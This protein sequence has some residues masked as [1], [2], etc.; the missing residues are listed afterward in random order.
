MAATDTIMYSI[1]PATGE[2]IGRYDAHTGAILQDILSQATSA[3]KVWSQKSFENRSRVF[4]RLAAVLRQQ[5]G[6]LA[7]LI[8]SE[9]GKPIRQAEAE[10]AKCAWLCDF[11]AENAEGYLK[12]EERPSDASRSY[13]Q[14]LPLGVILAIMPWNY[15][16]WQVLR[17]AIPALMAGNGAL[18]K[19]APN[20]TGCALELEKLLH[21][22][23]LEPGCFRTI[24]ASHDQIPALI[25]DPRVRGVT[26]TGSVRA[27]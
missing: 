25:E 1:N 3:Q 6:K 9:M 23:D 26:L 2:E 15:P 7:Q 27:G 8:T 24:I 12:T 20:V 4:Q 11:Y 16:F 10:I 13:V 17:F 18:L 21:E 22:C 14:F 5:K 19:H